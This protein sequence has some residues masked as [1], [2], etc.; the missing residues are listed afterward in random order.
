M[1]QS[2]SVSGNGNFA[3]VIYAPY[4]TVTVSGGGSSGDMLGAM[5]QKQH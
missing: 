2:I 1:S 5:Q 4:S 3:G